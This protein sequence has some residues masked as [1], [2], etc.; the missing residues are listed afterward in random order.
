ML[1]PIL[2]VGLNR[3]F[4]YDYLDFDR[5]Y[6]M[7]QHGEHLS[8]GPLSLLPVDGRAPL[9]ESLENGSVDEA[10]RIFVFVESVV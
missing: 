10:S 4:T 1:E 5:P 3:M 7:S 2:V 9:D 8:L 6:N